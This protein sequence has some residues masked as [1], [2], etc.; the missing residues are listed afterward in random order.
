[1]NIVE[2][3]FL[4]FHYALVHELVLVLNLEDVYAFAQLRQAIQSQVVDALVECLLFGGDEL[5]KCIVQ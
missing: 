2:S 3:V 1:L 4:F 5:T